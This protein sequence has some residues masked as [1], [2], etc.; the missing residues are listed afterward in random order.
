MKVGV[1]RTDELTRPGLDGAGGIELGTKW[2]RPNYTAEYW[3]DSSFP[4]K[5]E[6]D[7]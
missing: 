3:G 5:Q 2:W 6:V 4:R 1:R 7:E